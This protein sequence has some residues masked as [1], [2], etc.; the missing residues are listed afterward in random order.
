MIE[1]E[2]KPD[3]EIA[4]KLINAWYNQEMIDRPPIRSSAHNAEFSFKEIHSYLKT[5][6]R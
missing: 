5:L 2:Y 6:C 1:L 4:M 3:I